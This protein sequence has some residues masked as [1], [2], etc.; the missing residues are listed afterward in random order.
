VPE[1][2]AVLNCKK[3][4][5]SLEVSIAQQKKRTCHCGL[6]QQSIDNQ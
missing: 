5:T 1:K 6:D 3:Q 2:I 4:A